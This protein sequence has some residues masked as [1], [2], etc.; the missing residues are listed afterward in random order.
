MEEWVEGELRTALQVI[1]LWAPG[2]RTTQ[3]TT[4]LLRLHRIE[5]DADRS[6]FFEGSEKTV[7]SLFAHQRLC[8]AYEIFR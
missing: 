1:A 7:E 2:H 3:V 8:L 4:L 6:L 5:A